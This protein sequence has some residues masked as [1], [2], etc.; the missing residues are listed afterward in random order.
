MKRIIIKNLNKTIV[1][2]GII[3]P[4]MV[5]AY[6]LGLIVFTTST[7]S[8]PELVVAGLA[9]ALLFLATNTNEIQF[10]GM[11]SDFIRFKHMVRNASIAILTS[12]TISAIGF[13][14]VTLI[15]DIFIMVTIIGSLTVIKNM[16]FEHILPY[17]VESD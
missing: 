10:V 14:T 16:L 3:I 12:I 6:L 8:I 15:K 17:R 2:A 5:L 1:I 4:A 9:L 7:I 13:V 11:K